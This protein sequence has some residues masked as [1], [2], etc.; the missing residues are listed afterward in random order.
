ME[1]KRFHSVFFLKREM[2][3]DLFDIDTNNPTDE[4]SLL[5]LQLTKFDFSSECKKINTN[6]WKRIN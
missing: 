5:S 6:K 4:F 1:I 2:R 3:K